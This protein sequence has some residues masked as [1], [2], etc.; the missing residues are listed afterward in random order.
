[1]TNTHIFLTQNP[2]NP[3]KPAGCLFRVD[4]RFP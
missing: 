2:Q 1:M 3:Q 4:S